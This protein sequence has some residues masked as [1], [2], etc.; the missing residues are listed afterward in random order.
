MIRRA[1]PEEASSLTALAL[2]SKAHWGY[3]AAFL[4]ACVGALTITPEYIERNPVFVSEKDG[5]ITGFC[6]LLPPAEASDTILLDNLYVDPRRMGQGYGKGLWHQAASTARE[7]GYRHLDIFADP[8]AEPFYLARGAVRI[9]DVESSAI[10][11][12][13]LPHLRYS[14]TLSPA[15]R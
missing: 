7:L 11:G 6:A 3:D 4:E 13:M 5:S 14:L 9:G 12:R 1:R 2:R 8:H 15:D 10:P